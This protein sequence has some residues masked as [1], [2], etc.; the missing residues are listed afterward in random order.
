[1]AASVGYW[2]FNAGVVPAMAWSRDRQLE[3]LVPV[4]MA[5]IVIGMLLQVA[6]FTR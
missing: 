3:G 2:I 4:T 1:V 5:V 6:V